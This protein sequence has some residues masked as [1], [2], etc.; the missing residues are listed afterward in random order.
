MKTPASFTIILRSVSLFALL[1]LLTPTVL[2]QRGAHGGFG[3]HGGGFHAG[4]G[5]SSGAGHYYGGS[6]YRGAYYGWRGGYYGGWHSGYW[7]YPHYHY[8]YPYYGY[9]WGFSIS[10]GWPYYPYAYW[11]WW[12]SP[13]YYYPYPLSYCGPSDRPSS[14]ACGP[15]KRNSSDDY[16]AKSS[17]KE[18]SASGHRDSLDK[19]VVTPPD[20]EST[21]EFDTDPRRTTLIAY[22]SPT[23]MVGSGP[24]APAASNANAR[25]VALQALHVRRAVINVLQTL[26]AMPPETRQRFIES[27]RFSSLSPAEREFVS[28]LAGLSLAS[29]EPVEEPADVPRPPQ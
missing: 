23:R 25:F 24:L 3:F 19:N 7:G 22:V 2:A 17:P 11:P 12:D 18:S 27:G 28:Q 5:F 13:Y 16:R 15:E 6:A 4:S 9:G 1:L 10:F 26:R 20:T 29:K 8:G 14:D 21:P